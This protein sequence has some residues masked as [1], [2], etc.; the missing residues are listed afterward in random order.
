MTAHQQTPAALVTAARDALARALGRPK[1][2]SAALGRALGYVADQPGR[3]VQAWIS[4]ETAMPPPAALALRLIA[5]GATLPP[6]VI[7]RAGNPNLGMSDAAPATNPATIVAPT[8]ISTETDPNDYAAIVATAENVIRFCS[9]FTRDV[10]TV[11]WLNH[12]NGRLGMT[13]LEFVRAD[14]ANARRRLLKIV[15]LPHT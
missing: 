6:D 13:P 8:Q 10:I 1:V 5:D 3:N 7:V 15:T 11:A 12:R 4:G 9:N 2:S 14:L